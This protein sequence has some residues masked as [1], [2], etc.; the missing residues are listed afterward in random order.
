GSGH[1]VAVQHFFENIAMLSVTLLFSWAIG[2]GVEMDHIMWV[3]GGVVLLS[4]MV[5]ARF[6]PEK[7]SN[8]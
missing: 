2:S 7:Q 5:I 8:V 4:T 1:A 3:L 6:L